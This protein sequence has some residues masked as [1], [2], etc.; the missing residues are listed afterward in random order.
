MSRQ[1]DPSSRP[2]PVVLRKA[3][4]VPPTGRLQLGR[5]SLR[6]RPSPL[7]AR[8]PENGRLPHPSL[9]PHCQAVMIAFM[10]VRCRSICCLTC[11]F[12]RRRIWV[13]GSERRQLQPQLH[14][15]SDRVLVTAGPRCPWR[16]L[17]RGRC[18]SRAE[19]RIR[20][21][22]RMSPLQ[23]AWH[24]ATVER[25]RH[26]ESMT[27][28]HCCQMPDCT[29]DVRTMVHLGNDRPWVAVYRPHLETFGS[30][31]RVRAWMREQFPH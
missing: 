9:L 8:A 16:P 25:F 1:K 2:P 11:P 17:Q 4:R 31:F 3:P 14:P 5:L 26:H 10:A 7:R 6:R 20:A 30:D 23:P 27:K 13:H 21:P 15:P 29:L 22:S 28:A 18:R 19:R 24:R 12:E